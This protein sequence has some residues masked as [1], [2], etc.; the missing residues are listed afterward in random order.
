MEPSLPITGNESHIY[1]R[2][3]TFGL[4]TSLP[5]IFP[6]AT[7]ETIVSPPKTA[8][9]ASPPRRVPVRGGNRLRTAP[10]TRSMVSPR[11][12]DMREISRL[13]TPR[14]RGGMTPKTGTP[15]TVRTNTLSHQAVAQALCLSSIHGSLKAA[16]SEAVVTAPPAVEGSV[17]GF[18]SAIYSTLEGRIVTQSDAATRVTRA[19]AGTRMSELWHIDA[20]EDPDASELERT[21]VSSMADAGD[22]DVFPTVLEELTTRLRQT[23][24]LETD[25]LAEQLEAAFK[26]TKGPMAIDRVLRVSMDALGKLSDT[27][28]HTSRHAKRAINICVE[29][30]STVSKRYRQL[31]G[32]LKADHEAQLGL[33]RDEISSLQVELKTERDTALAQKEADLELI[34][35]LN[36]RAASQEQQLTTLHI[37]AKENDVLGRIKQFGQEQQAASAQ[38]FEM[39][40]QHDRIRSLQDELL[41]LRQALAK[42]DAVIGHRDELVASLSSD[43]NNLRKLLL[44]VYG[45]APLDFMDPSNDKG[46]LLSGK[47]QLD[48][49]STDSIVGSGVW[50]FV[51]VD[52][53][54]PHR[55]EDIVRALSSGHY[56]VTA[57]DSAGQPDLIVGGAE[58]PMTLSK[59]LLTE[60]QAWEVERVKL[61]GQ[62][63]EIK[64]VDVKA[65]GTK[66]SGHLDPTNHDL[67]KQQWH[68]ERMLLQK[69]LAVQRERLSLD[70]TFQKRVY[71]IVRRFVP[72]LVETNPLPTPDRHNEWMWLHRLI[73]VLYAHISIRVRGQLNTVAYG[74][75]SPVPSFTRMVWEFLVGKYDNAAPALVAVDLA[76]ACEH[77]RAADRWIEIFAK[78][79]DGERDISALIFFLHALQVSNDSCI[80]LAFPP[81][82]ETS[83]PAYIDVTRCSA[84]VKELFPAIT[85][86]Q[87][88]LF[89]QAV[90]SASSQVPDREI[91]FILGRES[92]GERRLQL[93]VFLEMCIQQHLQGVRSKSDAVAKVFNAV[94]T[95]HDG[96]LLFEPF[97]RMVEQLDPV[98]TVPQVLAAYTEAL[99]R[100]H[101]Q[102]HAGNAGDASTA[103]GVTC[104]SVLWVLHRLGS[105]TP[106]SRRAVVGMARLPDI[107]E[108]RGTSMVDVL[109][110]TVRKHIY[111]LANSVIKELGMV[112]SVHRAHDGGVLG[113]LKRASPFHGN[114]AVFTSY[115]H[116]TR[117]LT[118]VSSRDFNCSILGTRA[119]S[120]YLDDLPSI[121]AGLVEIIC[122]L[123]LELS[124]K[125]SPLRCISSAN[126]C[127]SYIT[128][129]IGVVQGITGAVPVD[130][131]TNAVETASKAIGQVSHATTLT[132][133]SS[134]PGEYRSQAAKAVALSRSIIVVQGLMRSWLSRYRAH[135]ESRGSDIDDDQAAV[136]LRRA[137]RRKERQRERRERR[138]RTG[139]ESRTEDSSDSDEELDAL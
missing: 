138:D 87:Y 91:A 121:E 4:G 127:L 116:L 77:H 131:M 107:P 64:G 51:P 28:G 10:I 59:S 43:I 53:E 38:A 98:L 120:V 14:T 95:E 109:A 119:S 113:V 57:D 8:R 27:A 67:L 47:A 104:G 44:Q 72:T 103:M 86:A 31:I 136:M 100:Q 128:T 81:A 52:T 13:V 117:A 15:F 90:N 97:K 63:M 17:L 56:E 134:E 126:Y 62:L 83:H 125:G 111:P 139:P 70:P 115:P 102:V 55:T 71:P 12:S 84:V 76:Q 124:S 54:D 122:S 61:L 66:F 19:L 49:V 74:T 1:H 24:I 48:E 3:G 9:N 40:L 58:P 133:S 39:D 60:R 32:D 135:D 123:E 5:K 26:T 99:D 132:L 89:M 42:K 94:D 112:M 92:L 105:L 25:V 33:L 108:Q 22:I 85:S 129:A 34:E 130:I 35:S 30:L 101:Q 41:N 137:N 11:D 29:Q 46:G 23:K 82:P 73:H 68:A 50:C 45:T 78:F 2:N 88:A 75:Y 18:L 36:D 16:Q 106:Y 110:A 20:P 96:A 80:G 93:S 37:I 21:I 114:V 79:F 6:N 65:A 118:E 7:P 69:E